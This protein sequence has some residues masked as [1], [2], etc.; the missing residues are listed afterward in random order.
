LADFTNKIPPGE[1][2]RLIPQQIA[3]ND[4]SDFDRFH[5]KYRPV[6]T[7]Y[8]A[9]L[10]GYKDPLQDLVQDVFFRFYKQHKQL[11][12]DLNP[13]TYLIGIAKNVLREE[14]KRLRRIPTVYIEDLL[15]LGTQ[16]TRKSQDDQDKTNRAH[17]AKTME[18]AKSKLPP[19]FHEALKLVY[20]KGLRVA[21]AAKQVGCTYNQMHW[22]I[23]QAK[24]QLKQLIV[25]M[26]QKS[27]GITH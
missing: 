11:R 17:L 27:K 23:Y 10:I 15:E 6:V 21:D 2:A 3:A 16:F 20:D 25:K 13:K 1:N 24:G 18:Q 7:D 5:S 12:A 22:R 8:L 14:R 4:L 9:S 19:T 26:E